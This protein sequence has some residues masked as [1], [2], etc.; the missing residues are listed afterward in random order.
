MIR[1][2]MPESEPKPAEVRCLWLLLAH[3]ILE[4]YGRSFR[5]LGREYLRARRPANRADQHERRNRCFL[6]VEF[7]GGHVCRLRLRH[8]R[9]SWKAPGDA[10]ASAIVYAGLGSPAS[11]PTKEHPYGHGRYETLAGLASAQYCYWLEPKSSGTE[12]PPSAADRSRLYAL[13]PLLPPLLSKRILADREISRR[14][15]HCSSMALQTDGWH[16]ITDLALHGRCL[17]RRGP[18]LSRIQLAS[19]PQ[20]VSAVSSSASLFSSWRC[21]WCAGR[22][23]NCSIRC[24]NLTG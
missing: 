20:I 9:R 12:L 16:D 2:G 24:R 5:C 1:I 21:R 3:A 6:L 13:Y 7:V 23:V 10:L 22:L 15:S 17:D 11:L 19:P 18:R 8:F 14:Q 4:A